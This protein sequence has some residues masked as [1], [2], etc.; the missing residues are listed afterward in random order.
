M[1]SY[2]TQ[3]PKRNKNQASQRKLFKML[4][5]KNNILSLLPPLSGISQKEACTL[6]IRRC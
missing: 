3:W 2:E 1:K 6:L 5:N 4:N